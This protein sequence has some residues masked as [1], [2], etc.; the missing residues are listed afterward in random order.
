MDGVE[1]AFAAEADFLPWLRS[2]K[3]PCSST[4]DLFGNLNG[5]GESRATAWEP[6]LSGLPSFIVED[7]IERQIASHKIPLFGPFS[8]E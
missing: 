6:S 2:F 8:L 7:E 1:S 3:T 5:E 4:A